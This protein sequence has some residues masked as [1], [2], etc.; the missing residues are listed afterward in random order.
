MVWRRRESSAKTDSQKQGTGD[1]YS[2]QECGDG[3]GLL[4]MRTKAEVASGDTETS[5]SHL[6][7]LRDSKRNTVSCLG[8]SLKVTTCITATG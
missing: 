6:G 8:H 1:L 4:R 2:S 5:N 3:M 7:H